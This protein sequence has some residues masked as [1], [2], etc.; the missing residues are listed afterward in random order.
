MAADPASGSQNTTL[1]QF[2]QA[3]GWTMLVLGLVSVLALALIVYDFLTIKIEKLAPNEFSESLVQ[4]LESNDPHGA[5]Q[6]CEKESNI[7][8]AIALAGLDRRTKGKTIMREAMENKAR[9]EIGKLWQNLSYLGDIATIAPLLGLLG[10]V[11][12]MIEAFNVISFAGSNL[13]PIMLVGGISKSL[14]CTAAGLVIAIP[15][16]SCYSY[17]RGKVQYISDQVEAYSSDIMR[18]IEDPHASK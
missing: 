15:C 3:G 8:S 4:K 12:G 1:W 11:L 18:L 6:L 17:F 2:L 14:V 16:M 10:T 13:K 7:I 9:K 5:R